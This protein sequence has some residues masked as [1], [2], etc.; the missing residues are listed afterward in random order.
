MQFYRK[1]RVASLMRE[2]LSWIIRR[3]IEFPDCL[4]T[5]TEIDVSKKL[6]R[7][8]VRV[9]VL[10]SEKSDE[11]LKILGREAGRLQHLLLKDMNIKPMPRISFIP[12]QGFENAANVEKALLNDDNSE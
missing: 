11:A 7:A 3:E 1:D 5:I 2:R 4:V 9:S 6:D 10:P 12:D 8:E